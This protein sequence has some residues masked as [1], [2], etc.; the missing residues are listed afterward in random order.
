RH[1]DDLLGFG[2]VQVVFD[3]RIEVL[4]V[5]ADDH[6]VNVL[7]AGADALVGFAGTN[8]GVEVQ[9]LAEGDVDG[10]EAGADGRG[11]RA[12][13]GDPV[14]ANGFQHVVGQRGP[15]GLHNVHARFYHIPVERRTG[16]RD[17]GFQ[18]AA[19]GLH[20]FG[21]GT[22]AADQRHV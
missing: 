8:T 20:Q 4:G 9:F 3:T 18:H 7:V 1:R 11:D 2:R 13:E 12:F 15:G 5:L 10:A 22:V 17:G 21:A 16:G 6:D 19:G 14:L